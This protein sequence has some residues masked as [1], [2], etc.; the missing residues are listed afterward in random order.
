LKKPHN[1]LIKHGL[2]RR[3][4]EYLKTHDRREYV[5]Y[6][7]GLQKQPFIQEALPIGNV[8]FDEIKEKL[9]ELDFTEG[10]IGMLLKEFSLESIEDAFELFQIQNQTGKVKSAKKWIF[11]CLKGGF[12]MTE[13]NKVRTAKKEQELEKAQKAEEQDKRL[14]LEKKQQEKVKAL[15]TQIDMW[16]GQNPGQYYAKC[17]EFYEKLKSDNNLGLLTIIAKDAAKLGKSEV[18]VIME[19]NILS[20]MVREMIKDLV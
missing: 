13:L 15:S 9:L 5:V 11:A 17:I 14:E 4:P 2:I 10:Q 12:D 19:N 18:E 8:K 7:F 1:E 20:S 6:T 3:L 16:I